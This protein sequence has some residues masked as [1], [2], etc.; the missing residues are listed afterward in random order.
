MRITTLAGLGAL[1]LGACALDHAAEPA[2]PKIR[3][4]IVSGDD[5]APAHNWRE[6]TQA[7]REALDG[8][9]KFDVK[10]SEDMH[11]LESSTALKNYDLVYY[12]RYNRQGTLSDAA[13]QNLLGFVAG[14]KGFVVTHLASASFPEW[15]EFRKMCGRYW[16]MGRSGHGPRGKFMATVVKPAHPIL[17]GVTSFE[18]DDELYAKLEG[19]GPIEVLMQAD[20]DWSKKIEPLAFTLSY[21]QGRVFH[22][23]F[24]HDGKATREPMVAKLI[25]NGAQW[26][27]TGK[28]E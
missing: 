2:T 3:V 25:V 23:T 5:V 10:V 19:D 13:K 11:I 7:T 14:G 28:V 8:S 16:V 12:T 18:A 1:L 24:G 27:A 4:L 17:K 6:M 20:S 9:G 15:A 22:H 26:A 21:G